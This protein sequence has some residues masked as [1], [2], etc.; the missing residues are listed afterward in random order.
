MVCHHEDTQTFLSLFH[1][2]THSYPSCLR[3]VAALYHVLEKE[4]E[5]RKSQGRPEG[6]ET[7]KAHKTIVA[8]GAEH[9]LAD[10]VLAADYFRT[11]FFSSSAKAHFPFPMYD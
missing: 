5:W 11:C 10:P 8:A 4:F 9:S 7:L 6:Y 2:L 1:N 3:N